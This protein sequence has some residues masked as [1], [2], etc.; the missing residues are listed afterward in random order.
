MLQPQLNSVAY[1]NIPK[2]HP[3]RDLQ[4][5]F[6][7]SDPVKAGRPGP[8]SAD[9]KKD[10]EE[11]FQNVRQVHEGGKYGSIG[12]RY[13]WAEDESLKCVSVFPC[14]ATLADFGQDSS[15]GHTRRP[16]RPPCC[17]SWLVSVRMGVSRQLGISLSTGSSGKRS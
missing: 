6:Y 13:P 5:T 17:T 2:Q 7:V 11:Y 12:Y 3:A 15:C 14:S 10:Y 9:D 16:S 8:T 1:V 4:D